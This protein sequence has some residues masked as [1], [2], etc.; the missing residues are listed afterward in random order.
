[1]PT[2]LRFWIPAFLL[3]LAVVAGAAPAADTKPKDD[4]PPPPP[5]S[6]LDPLGRDTP[7]GTVNGFLAA[8]REGDYERAARFLDLSEV[9][10]AERADG[11]AELARRIERVLLR[12][13]PLDTKRIS[14][15][16][17]G[18]ADDGLPADLERVGWVEPTADS[19][20]PLAAELRRARNDQHVRIWQFTPETVTQLSAFY[21]QLG[22][23]R[24][25]NLLPPVFFDV[26]V[27]HVQLWQW[28]A[29]FALLVLSV[30]ASWAAAG[31]VVR[32]LRPLA[33]RT[34]T[35]IDDRLLELGIAPL[36]L[37]VGVVLFSAGRVALGLPLVAT[38]V[39]HVGE[40]FLLAIAVT[41]AAL[42]LLDVITGV[43]EEKL[44]RRDQ[45]NAALVLPPGRRTAKVLV[46]C[47]GVILYMD[48]LGFDVT[49]VLAG[50]GVGG[51]A[52]ALAA[53]KSV[54]NLFGGVTLYADQPLR[55]G[56]TCRVDDHVGTVE[57]I[58][59]RSTRLRTPDRTMVTIPNA[60]L[61]SLAIE[62]LSRRDRMWFHPKL[63]LRYETSPEQLRAILGRIR[64]LLR[65]H[66]LV[67]AETAR[68]NFVDFGAY[69]LD[70]EVSAFVRTT[71]GDRFLEVAEELNLAL[72]D[73]VT[74]AGS[75]FAFP[76]QTTYVEQGSGLDGEPPARGEK[77]IPAS[78][79][80]AH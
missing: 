32:I 34:A 70:L 55:V 64:E 38:R 63:A 36:R 69:S 42:R 47:L 13:V 21:D 59:L 72:M 14:D 78:N 61:A 33:H 73:I 44:L 75:S 43:I 52:V 10:A 48:S 46:V 19:E 50:L 16:P 24:L 40:S 66:E 65:A 60:E 49:A 28:V 35:T 54:E 80:H 11:G 41:W 79:G 23:D 9:P 6:A 7:R 8:T 62:N 68:V 15:D 20:K 3:L 22:Y 30:V 45:R 31:L 76:S 58:G 51:I 67:V 18:V 77:R 56:D 71:D 74:A 53:Q 29:L 39:L 26:E 25:G 4:A 5:S 2:R 17:T 57:D 27:F 1:M 37:G 12:T